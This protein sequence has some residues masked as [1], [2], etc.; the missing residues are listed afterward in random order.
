M[1]SR[2]TTKKKNSD[3][4]TK[5]KVTK[6]A[7]VT[8]SQDS[9]SHSGVEIYKTKDKN[10]ETKGKDEEK[11]GFVLQN[12]TI[13][14]KAFFNEIVSDTFEHDYEDISSNG[15]V[16]FVDIDETRFY[17][18]KKI[19]LKKAYAPTEWKNLKSCLL[20]FIT[21]Q[22]YSEDG[23]EIKISGMSKLLDQEKQFTYKNTKIS[24]ILKDII[25]SA[26]LKAK[27]DTTGLKD[28]K[29]DYTN[30]SSSGSKSS[31]TGGISQTIDE[32]V[33]DAIGDETDEYQKAVKIHNA[34]KKIIKYH[35]HECS[36]YKTPDDC[37]KNCT[38]LNCADTSR[39]TCA[40]FRSAGLESFVV[41][42]PGHFWTIV[43][44][45][46]KEYA[47]DLTGRS[48]QFSTHEFNHVWGGNNYT[49]KC[50]EAPS[51]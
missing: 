11:E 25:T 33:A 4:K 48:G 23:V 37:M 34:L 30:V 36:N 31:S 27:I 14:E 24:K 5:V 12:G 47:S 3:K 15:S 9:L 17:K 49:S 10:V 51:C 39:L 42:R 41:H 20:G 16:S 8:I 18:G 28:K 35:S 7:P 2:K 6:K 45:N 19:W 13:T 38:K 43:K 32:F 44:C 21:E 26:G 46:G 22:T 1:S 50:G 40:C 29:I